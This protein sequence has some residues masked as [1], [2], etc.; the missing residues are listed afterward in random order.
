MPLR[1]YMFMLRAP[2]HL[3]AYILFRQRAIEDR[4][5]H[6]GR[7][8]VMLSVIAGAVVLIALIGLIRHFPA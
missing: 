7:A 6:R 3:R 5:A 4:V 2:K 8:K 1:R